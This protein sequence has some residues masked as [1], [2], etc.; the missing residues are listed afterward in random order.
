MDDGPAPAILRPVTPG[1]KTMQS[2]EYRVVPAPRR[3]VRAKGARRAED[4]FARAIEA[5][6]NRMA[7]EGWEFVRSDTL[8][9]DH[10]DGWFRRA[11]TLYQT[12]LVFRRPVAAAQGAQGHAADAMP[13]P[14]SAP[15]VLAPA[16]ALPPIPAPDH[17]IPPPATVAAP[18]ASR[19]TPLPQAPRPANVGAP[20]VVP[21]TAPP[22]SLVEPLP[23]G[24]GSRTPPTKPRHAAE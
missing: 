19:F 17:D 12:L 10:K 11:V 5:E 3:G 1:G 15:A 7:A 22:L 24:P 9:H 4:R 14:V 18:A 16:Q 2:H 23:A 8:P 13:P 20:A 6:M 21:P